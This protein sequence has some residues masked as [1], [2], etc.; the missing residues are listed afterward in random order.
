MMDILTS[1]TDLSQQ[2]IF[3]PV[4]HH[5]PKVAELV[6]ELARDIQPNVILIEGPADYM[7]QFDEL[8]LEHQ[9]PIAIYSYVR[10]LTGQ[11]L[12]AFY[13]FSIYSP[14]WQAILV[15]KEIGA[16]VQFIDMP[17]AE[18]A[19]MEEEPIIHR[20]ADSRLGQSNYVKELCDELGVDGFDALWDKLFEVQTEMSPQNYLE[21]AHTFMY[22]LRETANFIRHSDIERE[23]FMISKIR[24]A[25]DIYSGKILVVTGGFHSSALYER[26]HNVPDRD[27]NAY[28]PVDL[29]RG[30][31]L[32]PYSYHRL[33]SLT[34]YES[35]MPNPGFYHQVWVDQETESTHD[36]HRTLLKQTALMLRDRKQSVTPADLIAVDTTAHALASLR[37]HQRVWRRDLIDGI[38][39]A[40]VKDELAYDFSHPFLNAIH[41]LFRGNLIGRLAEGT[42]VPP[43]A[44]QINETL[45]NYDLVPTPSKHG[46]T[47]DLMQSDELER[48]RILHQLRVLGI[49]GFHQKGKRVANSDE[50][51]EEWLIYWQPEFDAAVIERTI[52]GATL[53]DASRARLH[54]TL[55]DIENPTAT[56]AS[57]VLLDAALMGMPE[58]NNF[59]LGLT[60]I[61]GNDQSFFTVTSALDT[62]LFLYRFDQVLDTSKHTDVGQLLSDTF[63]HGVWLLQTLGVVQDRDKDLLDGLRA[64]Q[65]TYERCG[66]ILKIGRSEFVELFMSISHDDEQ[67][68]VMRGAVSGV[69]LLLN[70]ADDEAILK[71]MRYFSQPEQLGDFL[72][73]LF[74]MAREPI[75]RNPDMLQRIDDLI[76]NYADD[77]FLI[78]VPSLRLAF[79]FFTPREKHHIAHQLFEDVGVDPYQALAVD[80][81]ATLHVLA[82]E[83]EL[84]NQLTQ[85]GLWEG[86]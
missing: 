11:R 50:T 66:E 18:L 69:L 40:L 67:T 34:G 9:L 75:Q 63:T 42:A 29:D 26:L 46:I 51:H 44:E 43:L 8:Y 10:L 27:E 80:Y 24:E 83:T 48:S 15:G 53:V 70:E 68:P 79:S 64:L 23:A 3:F 36:T 17:W 71:D 55:G 41:E 31:A 6:R 38:I 84:F 74:F 28:E 81:N 59:Y 20:Y 77:D 62:L 78:A 19:T 61:I 45:K 37:G 65:E 56:D 13:P 12:G 21:R 33:D 22:H 5:S 49:P 39:S 76:T 1:I 30:I 73:G 85:Y 14:E 54:E 47:L 72:T 82:F 86:D 25:L 52:Y 57:S 2:V 7:P 58:S 35:G 60:H 32:T 4:R 16:D